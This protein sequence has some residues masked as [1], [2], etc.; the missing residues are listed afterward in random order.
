MSY[1][2]SSCCRGCNFSQTKKREDGKN[3][4]TGCELGRVEKFKSLGTEV[5]LDENENGEFFT[6]SRFCT[7]YRP[8]EWIITLSEEEKSDLTKTVREEISVR[9]GI[10]ILFDCSSHTE[11]QL[12]S[13]IESFG[14]QTIAPRYVV[15]VSS[16]AEYNELIHS[17]LI[18]NFPDKKQT[19]VHLV[20]CTDEDLQDYFKI[21]EAFKH[22]LN[23]FYYVINAGSKHSD[24]FI[25][26]FDSYIN[27]ELS[28]VVMVKPNDGLGGLLMQ[29]SLHKM[30]SGSRTKLNDD[31]SVN[32]ENIVQRVTTMGITN[33]GI[34]LIK[35]WSEII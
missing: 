31:E 1:D 9:M 16:R 32:T 35:D 22:A 33:G 3:L 28:Q 6:I 18:D 5:N 25:E 2:I 30:L 21:D 19:N 27:D 7:C 24:D 14:R 10:I 13:T 4:Q 20:Q 26:K 17:L 29:A 8:E 15:V 23:G 11:D 12:K 34:D